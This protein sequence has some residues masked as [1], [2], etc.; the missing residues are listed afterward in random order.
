METM[1][2]L[3]TAR[4][5]KT[6]LVTIGGERF[7]EA[8]LDSA[9]CIASTTPEAMQ[10]MPCSIHTASTYNLT[11]EVHGLQ[12]E[13]SLIANGYRNVPYLKS[14][15][16]KLCMSCKLSWSQLE[17][18]VSR[19]AEHI[20]NINH[21]PYGQPIGRTS[22]S[23]A[24]QIIAS[25]MQGWFEHLAPI[26]PSRQRLGKAAVKRLGNIS[27]A[28]EEEQQEEE[29]REKGEVSGLSPKD[30]EAMLISKMEEVLCLVVA[31]WEMIV[32]QLISA[33]ALQSLTTSLE[34]V[35][36]G[37]G[38]SGVLER[39][40]VT[41]EEVSKRYPWTRDLVEALQESRA[42]SVMYSEIT[43]NKGKLH[44]LYMYM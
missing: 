37:M 12:I 4:R 25:K 23:I 42:A 24:Q 19:A 3:T 11:P 5:L 40:S 36:P 33:A 10:Q 2:D 18:V 30:H 34:E 39:A 15:L 27:E 31:I 14:S 9:F 17:T 1:A 20:S 43:D 41:C 16:F 7:R 28:A 38:M 26:T 22:S 6:R 29:T 35:F 21:T 13:S 32:P 8:K 44:V